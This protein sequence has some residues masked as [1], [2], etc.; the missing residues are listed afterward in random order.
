MGFNLGFKRLKY[1]GVVNS[2][3]WLHILL[4]PW[5]CT[6]RMLRCSEWVSFRTVQRTF[7]TMAH[8]CGSSVRN[9]LHVT[10]GTQNFKLAPTFFEY[11]C[12]PGVDSCQN[13]SCTKRFGGFNRGHRYCVLCM[14]FVRPQ[15]SWLI[16]FRVSQLT[17][18]Q[19]Q[20]LGVMEILCSTF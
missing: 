13:D 16:P 14:Q 11:S 15:F 8:I 12:T 5:W 7:C 9:M 17:Y 4:G 18:L 1:I 10:P 19:G 3:V 20:T 2:V 6:P